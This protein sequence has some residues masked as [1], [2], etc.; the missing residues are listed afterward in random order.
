MR[1][2]RTALGRKRVRWEGIT[3][4]LAAE[5]D[6]F[7]HLKGHFDGLMGKIQESL[8]LEGQIGILQGSLGEALE[9]LDRVAAEG[10]ELRGRLT[11]A[12]Q[13]EF[14]F[15]SSRLHYFGLKPRR[16][17][18]RHKKTAQPPAAD[19]ADIANIAET[20]VPPPKNPE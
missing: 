14:G 20:A 12:L 10:E 7:P 16:P 8:A 18:G 1:R 3:G 13:A 4:N 5:L 2:P 6:Q 9:R 11:A 19:T 17:R 15:D